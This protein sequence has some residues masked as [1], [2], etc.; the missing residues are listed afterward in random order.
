[1]DSLFAFRQY[2]WFD[3]KGKKIKVAAPQYI[4]FVMTFIQKTFNDES[5][6]PIKFGKANLHVVNGVLY[7]M[8]CPNSITKNLN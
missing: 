7:L 4:D 1:M 8:Q 2:F 3:D 6:F 5:V